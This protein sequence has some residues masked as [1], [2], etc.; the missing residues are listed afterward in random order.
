MLKMLAVVILLGF[1]SGSAMP[2]QQGTAT[3]SG[4]G[5]V[6]GP[7]PYTP[8]GPSQTAEPAINT[9]NP[10]VPGTVGGQLPVTGAAGLGTETVYPD[11]E[12]YTLHAG[13]LISIRLY[14]VTDYFPTVRISDDGTASLPLIGKVSLGDLTVQQAEALIANKLKSDGMYRNP[15]VTITVAE[16]RARTLTLTGEMHGVFFMPSSGQRNLLDVLAAAGGLPA[17]ASRT[18][19]IIRPG[20]EQPIMVN[21]GTTPEQ[22][23]KAN[24]PVFAHD[25]IFVEKTGVVY[26]L[27]AFKYS[28]VFPMQ[29]GTTTLL[30]VAALTGGPVYQAKYQDMR[31]IRT[32]GT[33]RTEVKLDIKKVMDGQAPD[34]I[35]PSGDI[36]FLPTSQ[37]KTAIASNGI[38][39]LLGVVSLL[40]VAFRP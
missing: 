2:A 19:S 36:L 7:N 5:Q 27:G 6:A 39:T 30:Q 8:A 21:L 32:V 31:I 22:M 1:V 24:I 34:P 11:P 13:D 25:T 35:L 16:S 4:G 10:N 18:I 9:L 40:I 26:A 28:G 29:S 20:V 15:E 12:H 23:A 33:Q 37:V 14:A 38:N 17:T 3:M